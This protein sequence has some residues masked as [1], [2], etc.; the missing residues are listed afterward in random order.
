MMK[1][2]MVS[3]SRPVKGN[4]ARQRLQLKRLT[5][6]RL[7]SLELR[8]VAAGERLPLLPTMMSNCETDCDVQF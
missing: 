3:M 4:A 5:L 1:K 6:H 8:Q 7:T 2:P